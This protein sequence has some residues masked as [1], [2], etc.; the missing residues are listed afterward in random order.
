MRYTTERHTYDAYGK[1]VL[2]IIPV[3]EYDGNGVVGT[4]DSGAVGLAFGQDPFTIGPIYDLDRN[5]AIGPGDKGQVSNAFGLRVTASPRSSVGN[6]Y[7][8]TGRTTDQIDDD[9]NITLTLQDNRN[10]TYDLRHGRWLQRDPLLYID[11]MNL[12]Q[13]ARSNPLK[14][15]DPDGE[16]AWFV[17]NHSHRDNIEIGVFIV[18]WGHDRDEAI[19]AAGIIERAWKL[20]QEKGVV[21][22][23]KP[24]TCRCPSSRRRVH[25]QVALYRWED[26]EG[27]CVKRRDEMSTEESNYCYWEAAAYLGATISARIDNRSG[28]G[29]S[30]H[31]DDDR[32]STFDVGY[33]GDN[34]FRFPT[35]LAHEFGHALGYTGSNDSYEGPHCPHKGHLMGK[36]PRPRKAHCHEMRT[37]LNV[38]A[39]KRV[40]QQWREVDYRCCVADDTPP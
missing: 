29:G 39:N 14:M 38:P 8:F 23:G 36:A 27:I 19:R 34:P 17:R 20:R 7:L 18:F 5:G 32:P 31:R 21:R 4:G 24:V 6:P 37:V 35:L 9:T 11:S 25:V 40:R 28:R 12:Y 10:R 26:P 15:I 22:G 3:E 2:H 30:A 1:P 33:T 16:K 13:Y